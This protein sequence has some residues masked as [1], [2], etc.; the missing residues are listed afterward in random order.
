MYEPEVTVITTTHNIVD[1]G[2]ADDFTLLLNLLNKQT[3]PYIEHLVIDNASNDDTVDFLK[4]YK[5]LG[6]INFYSAPDNGK[7][8]AMN[9]GL[10]R[11]KGKYVAFLS[12]DD[13]YHDITGIADVVN[14]MEENE[15]DFCY[16]PSYCVPEDNN[17]FLF[18]PSP[19]NV[20]QVMPFPRQ[21]AV[22][23]RES[24]A[25]V[26]NFDAKFRLC[27]DYDLLIKLF[28]SNAKGIFFDGCIVTY[29]MGEQTLKHPTQLQLECEH[30]YHQNFRNL[31][32]LNDNVIDRMVQIAEIPKPLLEKLVK[33][34][35]GDEEIFYERYRQM[36]EL[37]K[38]NAE[39]RRAQERQQ[40][41]R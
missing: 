30:I 16:F 26:G 28:L 7:F 34:F 33:C 36:Y 19:Y 41:G 40:R 2:K 11:A 39:Y 17:V 29:R 23:N 14:L 35:P 9:K 32:P 6:Y 31:Y 4:E 1:A 21:A 3:Y 37:R 8:D 15:A 10:I 13:F 20:F 27:A 25:R 24:L 5:N 22:F 18:N 38:E 12:C